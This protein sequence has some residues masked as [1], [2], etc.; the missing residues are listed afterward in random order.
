MED[1][2]NVEETEE[3]TK[4]PK[5]FTELLLLMKP[6][7]YLSVAYKLHKTEFFRHRSVRD[8]LH[9]KWIG[10]C[11][12]KKL[13]LL[14]LFLPLLILAIFPFALPVALVVNINFVTRVVSDFNVPVIKCIF[15][16]IPYII[17]VLLL[18]YELLVDF[19]SGLSGLD[20]YLI[21]Y[22]VCYTTEE[23]R[24]MIPSSGI[25]YVTYLRSHFRWWNL[26]DICCIVC[27]VVGIVLKLVEILD[28][29]RVALAIDV[30]LFTLRVLALTAVSR[31]LGPKLVMIGKMF[32]DDLIPFM[33]ILF[34]FILGFSIADYSLLYHDSTLSYG[35]VERVLMSGYWILYGENNLEEF[36]GSQ[37][38]SSTSPC[39]SALGVAVVP[40]IRG[41]FAL[42]SVVLLLNVLIAMFNDTYRKVQDVS[43]MHWIYNYNEL[44]TEYESKPLLPPPFLVLIIPH[45]IVYCIG[46]I[47]KCKCRKSDDIGDSVNSKNGDFVKG[48]LLIK[49]VY[50]TSGDPY[51]KY[52]KQAGFKKKLHQFER[53]VK[54]MYRKRLIQKKVKRNENSEESTKNRLASLELEVS[55]Q[56]KEI[57]ALRRDLAFL[58]NDY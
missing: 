35:L 30:T 15:L 5:L 52:R 51:D 16:F 36:D 47:L 24:Q 42:L 17:F 29:S 45:T 14:K 27:F 12:S 43:Y 22:I 3:R 13:Q 58:L 56:S 1:C 2:N 19:S 7:D 8:V 38:E 39:P 41:F 46:W 28:I 21:L 37:C 44:I 6:E 34:V 53:K 40:Y 4:D 25:K 55:K 31:N 18:S 48:L 23:I 26:N 32:V 49:T 50:L 20:Y 9:R 54:E 10:E 11:T 57:E 33:V